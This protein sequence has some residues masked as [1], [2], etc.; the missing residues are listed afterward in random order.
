MV[1]PTTLY[2]ITSTSY[3]CD[4]ITNAN[5]VLVCSGTSTDNSITVSNIGNFPR[6]IIQFSIRGIRNPGSTL[7]TQSLQLFTLDSGSSQIDVKTTGILPSITPGTLQNAQLSSLS[8]VAGANSFLLVHF[9]TQHSVPAGSVIM[10]SFPKY[11]AQE[12]A[13]SYQL[14]SMISTNQPTCSAISV[15]IP[16]I[17]AL[18]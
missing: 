3:T 13:Q 9:T 4:G 1:F 14:K 6:T 8:Q 7:V 17:R 2:T 18:N 5:P 16:L 15:K 12:G 10:L 11:N